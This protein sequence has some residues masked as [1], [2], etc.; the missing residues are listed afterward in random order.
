VTQAEQ[1][2]DFDFLMAEPVPAAK[3]GKP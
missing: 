1:G 3:D 2:C